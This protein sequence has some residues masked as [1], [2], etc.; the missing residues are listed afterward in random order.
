MALAHGCDVYAV[1]VNPTAADFCRRRGIKIVTRDELK[2]LRFDFINV[3]QVMEHLTDPLGVARLLAGLLQPWGMMKWSTPNNP[4]LPRLLRAAQASGDES[5][6]N[7]KTIDSLA[8]LEHV[9][10]FSNESLKFLGRQVGLEPVRLPF[11]KWMGA[12]QIWNLPRQLN[13]NLIVP[14]KRFRMKGTYLWF[15]RRA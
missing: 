4:E 3:D 12:G 1:E 8:P 2:D 10:L 7:P 13:R 15:K 6:L 11:W 14:L 5:V 9:N